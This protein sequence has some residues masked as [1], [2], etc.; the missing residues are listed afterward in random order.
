MCAGY[1]ERSARYFESS[2]CYFLATVAAWKVASATFKVELHY[3]SQISTCP[4]LVSC[5][6]TVNKKIQKIFTIIVD[7][8]LTVLF[9]S[10][11]SPLW[12]LMTVRIGFL[13]FRLFVM[14]LNW[15][16]ITMCFY[17]LSL[18]SANND[19]FFG[20]LA[21]MSTAEVPAYI[22]A[23][24]MMEAFGRRSVLAFCQVSNSLFVELAIRL[25]SG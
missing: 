12:D 4:T 21:A 20:S 11:H 17:G 2:A 10:S 16:V 22:A 9:C 23:M 15:V 13:C 6:N 19:D 5:N 24:F 8:F 3:L 1:F 18:N 25:L 7:H 14:S